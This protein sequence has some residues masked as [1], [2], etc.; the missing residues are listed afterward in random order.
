[1]GGGRC[2]E[3]RK[4]A[5]HFNFSLDF[6]K[7]N[8]EVEKRGFHNVSQCVLYV[9]QSWQYSIIGLRLID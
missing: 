8:S 3:R 1:M 6:L 9:G 2:D 5:I 7:E 4:E